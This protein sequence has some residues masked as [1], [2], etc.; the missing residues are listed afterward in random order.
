MVTF[1]YNTDKL[2]E[3]FNED[4]MNTY[5]GMAKLATPVIL[6]GKRNRYPIIDSFLTEEQHLLDLIQG[7]WFVLGFLMLN[8]LF[9]ASWDHNQLVKFRLF[10]FLL[11][12][13]ATA[14]VSTFP[15]LVII[16][17]FLK[18]LYDAL[19]G[20]TSEKWKLFSSVSVFGKLDN[21]DFVLNSE[22]CD[23]AFWRS[24]GNGAPLRE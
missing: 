5:P 24:W 8:A 15:A 11:T 18:A 3:H 19:F 10:T 6:Y 16:S 9:L 13:G 23:V 12:V 1:Y 4:V 14:V 2:D 7:V 21:I 17:P 20:K 22:V